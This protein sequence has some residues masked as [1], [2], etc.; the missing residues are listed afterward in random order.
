MTFWDRPAPP[1]GK[2]VAAVERILYVVLAV[3]LLGTVATAV[4]EF[5]DEDTP[6]SEISSWIGA[7]STALALGVF[8]AEQVRRVAGWV[9]LRTTWI[10][11]GIGDASLMIAIV[12]FF[13]GRFTP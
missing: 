4:P 1:P 8:L 13:Y 5:A 2:K 6:I 12:A 3:L 9:G 7:F 10:L 11:E